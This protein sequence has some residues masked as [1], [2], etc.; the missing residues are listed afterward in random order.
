M[1]SETSVRFRSGDVELA[2]RLAAPANATLG[3]VV[4][5]PHPLYGG[6]MDSS[7]VVAVA[8]ALAQAGIATLRFDFRGAGMSGGAHAGGIPE[9][10][11][12]RAAGEMLA[13]STGGGR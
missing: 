2:G 9:I 6:D 5:H 1:I 7:F 12:A 13:R 8:H 4:C 11:D 3:C 10:E